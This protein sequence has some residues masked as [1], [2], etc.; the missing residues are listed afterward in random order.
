MKKMRQ[1]PMMLL[2]GARVG[3]RGVFGN[4]SKE[5]TFW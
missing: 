3:W 2:E 5:A 4:R 1:R